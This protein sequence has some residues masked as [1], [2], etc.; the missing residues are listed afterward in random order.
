MLVVTE[1]QQTTA[2]VGG[3]GQVRLA[4]LTL[5]EPGELAERLPVVEL[6]QQCAEETVR[7]Y[8]NEAIDGR[9]GYQL[10]RRAI[11][12]RDD[13][14]WREV[15]RVYRGQLERWA[16]G[17]RLYPHAGEDAEALANRALENL[18]RRVDARGFAGFP[19]L[20]SI[21]GY[22]QRSVY[23]LVIDAARMRT[24]EQQR[25]EALGQSL[26]GRAVLSAQGHA[27]D[28]VR[29]HELWSS[30]R[31]HCRNERELRIAYCYLVLSLKP[32]DIQALFPTMFASTSVIN[33]TLATLLKRL[34][35]SPS[36]RRQF[37][38]APAVH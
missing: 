31:D 25:A 26:A 23:N 35:R 8:R 30:V 34:R 19:N 24:R 4:A 11:V 38:D 32:S 2:A 29:A 17:N 10:F 27:L 18:W 33:A 12:F 7:Y 15:E 37:Q 36:L 1:A 16:R 13:Q 5:F 3:L 22:L 21:L 20:S 9:Y 14:A 6:A 28:R